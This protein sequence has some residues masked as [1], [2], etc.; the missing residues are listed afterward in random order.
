MIRLL[1]FILSLGF[2][3]QCTGATVYFK[4]NVA[5]T[6]QCPDDNK[7]SEESSKAEI[8]K[9]Q[10]QISNFLFIEFNQTKTYHLP[11]EYKQFY[12]PGFYSKPFMPPR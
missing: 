1:F 4:K 10:D 6:E 11:V 5:E 9:D 2:F 3:I 8:K 12:P 7:S